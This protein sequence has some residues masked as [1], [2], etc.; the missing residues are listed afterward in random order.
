MHTRTLRR[1]APQ[2]GSYLL[3]V[4]RLS[5]SLHPAQ[6]ARLLRE[7]AVTLERLF[8]DIARLPHDK[9]LPSPTVAARRFTDAMVARFIQ[10]FG[11][12]SNG[13]LAQSLLHLRESWDLRDDDEWVAAT[14]DVARDIVAVRPFVRLAKDHDAREGTEFLRHIAISIQDRASELLSSDGQIG[15]GEGKLVA[16]VIAW[17]VDDTLVQW[18]E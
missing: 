8:E 12:A 13:A 14:G 17:S 7:Q 15:G 10:A 3:H 18:W 9:H 5:H 6:R 4:A 1:D 2:G 16:K 11:G